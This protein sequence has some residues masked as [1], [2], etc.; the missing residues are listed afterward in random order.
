MIAVVKK[1]ALTIS[2]SG[3]L[4][5]G[6]LLKD[7][8]EIENSS[9]LRGGYSEAINTKLDINGKSYVLR[10][11]PPH[12]SESEILKEFYTLESAS[13]KE[14]APQV[15]SIFPK[16]H[17]VLMAYIPGT[18]SSLVHPE[19]R[20]NLVHFAE[21]LRKVHQIERNPYLSLNLQERI[22][23]LYALLT[24]YT[25][26]LSEIEQA[27]TIIRR[28]QKALDEF[29]FQKV[30]I[31][32]DLNPHNIFITDTG[33]QLID[34]AETS[35][36]HPYYDLACFALLH[37]YS[38]EEELLLLTTYL[39]RSPGIEEKQQYALI[40][41]I[42][43]AMFCLSCHGMALK[44]QSQNPQPINQS[45]PLKNWSYYVRSFAED[46]EKLSAQ[47]FSEYAQVSLKRAMNVNFE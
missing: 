14:V 15:F 9:I 27:I 2:A 32:G 23:G 33:I 43:L 21:V 22:E 24:Q 25:K 6:I 20:V 46:N 34:W 13:K 3:A 45:S 7:L 35:W 26:N 31:H 29:Q 8:L 5:N 17:A 47:F 10:T 38:E 42:N 37:D 36:E 16:E 28:G 40:K 12:R 44:L 39:Q 18:H 41:K 11:Y 30:T 19:Q 1:I 4:F